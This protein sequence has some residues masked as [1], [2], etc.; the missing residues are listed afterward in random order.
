MLAATELSVGTFPDRTRANV[1]KAP[2][3]TR[4]TACARPT[5]SAVLRTETVARTRSVYNP[6]NA[7]ALRHSSQMRWITT[8]A[9]VSLTSPTRHQI[10]TADLFIHA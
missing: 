8:N 7:S 10:Q 4:I 9:R 3:V 1:R 6:E 2:V 5:R